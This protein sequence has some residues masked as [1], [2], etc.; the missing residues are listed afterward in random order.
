[1]EITAD[2]LKHS[3]A[4]ARKMKALAAE[5]PKEYLMDPEDAFVLGFLHD[6]GYEFCDEQRDH[7]NIGG[8][9]LKAQGYK[10]WKEIY[11]HGVPQ[12]EYD[13]PALRLL[14]YV[15]MITGPSGEEM[16]VKERIDD[17]AARYGKDSTQ[18]IEAI[19]LA[20]LLGCSF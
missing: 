12:N 18:E 7:A 19:E 10:Y 2:R 8:E 11:Y 16:T 4:V 6:I 17:I 9:I 3:L 5:F 20:R 1:M 14:N 15:D 13:S